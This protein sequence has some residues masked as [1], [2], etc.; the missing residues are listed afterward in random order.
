MLQA[1]YLKWSSVQSLSSV[2]LIATPWIAVR[3]ASQSNTNS[4]SLLKLM[5]IE[6]MLPSN[7]LILCS[8]LL[9]L[10]SIFPS[11]RVFLRSQFFASGDQSIAVSA[12]ASGLP[13]NIQD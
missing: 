7:H 9:L 1:L 4:Q 10:L 12:S 13:M 8:P 2:Q 6:L 3:Q 11:I 5:S